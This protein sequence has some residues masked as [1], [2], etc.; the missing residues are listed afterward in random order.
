MRGQSGS[1]SDAKT[2]PYQRP[3]F[4]WNPGETQTSP[5]MGPG[6][7]EQLLSPDS[8]KPPGTIEEAA[9]QAAEREFMQATKSREFQLM[10]AR[11]RFWDEGQPQ[12]EER[13]TDLTME[14]TWMPRTSR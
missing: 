2:R 12:S 14:F 1:D 4:N 3:E 9:K 13:L 8:E 7:R 10:N 5:G 11:Q 6:P